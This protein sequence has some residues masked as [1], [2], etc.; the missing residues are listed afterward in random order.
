MF[1]GKNKIHY[2]QAESWDEKGWKVTGSGDEVRVT[3]GS[4]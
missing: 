1:S 4:K 2:E 3:D